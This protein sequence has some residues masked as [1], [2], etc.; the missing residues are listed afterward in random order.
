MNGI[1]KL[2]ICSTVC[3]SLLIQCTN[4]ENR[5]VEKSVT[6]P[7][8]KKE[9][10]PWTRWWWMASA[11]D[12]ANIEKDLTLFSQAG[13]GGVEITPIYGAAGYESDYISFLSPEW[14][15]MLNVTIN[16]S[17]KL[18]MGVDMN[19]GTGWPFGGPQ[20]TPE[21]A[22]GKLIIQKYQVKPSQEGVLQIVVKDTL[23]QR[24]GA[25]LKGL[26]AYGPSK[27]KE[28]ILDKVDKNGILNWRPEKGTWDIYA[29]F[30]GHTGQ[31]VKRAA[32]GG[33]GL[34]MDHL[35]DKAL[36]IYL[37]RFDKAFGDAKPGVRSFF[38]DSYE[39]FG[40]DF[41]P[42]F[43]NVFMQRRGYDARMYLRELAVRD[44]SDL[45]MRLLSDYRL[46]MAEMVYENFSIPWRQWINDKGALSRNQAHGF[47]GNIIDI[48]AN[49]DI[50]EAETFGIN[51]VPVPG[52]KY[53]TNDTRN[54][55]P[56]IMM[57]KFASSA[58]NLL[59]KP[60]T[61]CETFTWL[62]EHFKVPLSNTKP[63]VERVF[64]AGV[65]HVFFHG[66][67]FSP[68]RADWPGWLFYAS[69]NFA[70]SNT[71]WP[72]LSGLTG[73]ITRCQSVL[74]SGKSDNDILLYWPYADA[75]HYGPR[76]SLSMMMTIHAI[77]QWLK[78][79]SFYRDANMLTDAGY[80][81]DFISDLLLGK[82][83]VN[84][85]M[86]R[87]SPDGP[88]YQVLIIPKTH[89][90]PLETFRNVLHLAEQG[91]TVIFDEMPGDVPGLEALDSNRKELKELISSLEFREVREGVRIAERSEGR[92]ILAHDII[93]ALNSEDIQGET[94]SES[95]L[96]FIRRR[97]GT[98]KYYFLVNHS[99]KLVNS[100]ISLNVSANSVVI[101]DPQ[102]GEYGSAEFTSSSTGTN[103]RLQVEPGNA[104]I[105]K[106]SLKENQGMNNWDYHDSFGPPI[107]LTGTWKL[108]FVSGGPSL[109]GNQIIHDLVSWTVLTDS[110]AKYFSGTAEYKFDFD[111]QKKGEGD[112]IIDLGDVRE[113]AH[114]WVNGKDAG[115][116]WHVPYKTNI[117]TY[118]K[119]G[120]NELKIEVA[121]LMANR[122]IYMDKNKIE[123]RRYHEINF[124]NLFYA[125]FDASGWAPMKSGLL[126]PVTI[127]PVN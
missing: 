23:Q 73:Y 104:V 86:L 18:G 27:E 91:A 122:I 57:M 102:T 68:E 10:H 15:N 29:A 45:T 64:L 116:L 58:A 66:S 88:E 94:I 118:L 6:W 100:Y 49:V 76:T 120:R 24:M 32:P 11:V 70:P 43:F 83:S 90:M 5:P 42:D 26:T 80:S 59:G 54:I 12:K 87:A 1:T 13:I 37:N 125:P 103:V 19:L 30:A 38:N 81:L 96:N 111:F 22:A 48:Y 51:R 117:G 47:P 92:I 25:V 35:S 114:L 119:N 40:A 60:L 99:D 124:V 21:F 65:N 78:P 72:H 75:R 14:M 3:L 113:S 127:T 50:P 106:T 61:S 28:E 79:T 55:P 16:K 39:V 108:K 115:I 112:Y 71:F 84:T 44:S 98:D 105:V 33:E 20:I 17:D 53:Y 89:F 62:G 9:T 46:T 109:P 95:G 110:S 126:G 7:E 123:W 8:V 4:T 85:G 107:Q 36:D 101:L 31:A 97:D 2:I 74:Q 56:D 77:D 41:T 69:T 67:T 93:G 121:N 82:C 63:E 34:V 52:M